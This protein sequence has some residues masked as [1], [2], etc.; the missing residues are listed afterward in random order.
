MITLEQIK[1]ISSST[2]S[3]IVM[4]VLDGLGGLPDP[5]TGKTELETARTPHLDK[6]ANMSMCGL[7]TPIIPGITPGSGPGHLALFGYDP[8][9]FDIG[10]GVLEALGI[11]FDLK[12]D[13]IASR[14]NFCTIDGKGIITDRRA[15]RISTEKCA[16]LCY[17]LN[18]I[19]IDGIQ[20]F[21]LPVKEHRLL[22]VLRGQGLSDRLHDT[23]PQKT[24]AQPIRNIALNN[25]AEY[26]ESLINQFLDKAAGILAD[27]SPANMLL[28]RGFS[29]LPDIPTFKNIYKLNPV[30]I[31]R[32]PM[33][34]GL[35]KLVGMETVK[36][37]SNISEQFSVLSKIY[38]K[39]DFFFIHIKETDS[40]GEDGDFSRKVRVI[41][42]VDTYIP[43]LM[44]L[45]PD[46]IIVTGDH[47]TPAVFKG[48]SWHPVPFL[49]FSNWCRLQR[50]DKFSESNC[51]NGNLGTFSAV[52]IMPLAMGHSLKL[53]KFGA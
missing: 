29:R 7:S 23:D 22:F 47:S 24:G 16:E 26:T 43:A 17:E 39:H 1:Q 6:L 30:A 8:L 11:G 21:I 46:V 34:K 20:Y 33:Y 38:D 49:I 36:A 42:E 41:E 27:H 3:K 32:Y 28:L 13:D 12:K 25:N 18:H 50:I 19:K 52:N 53:S 2:A 37:D 40:A 9:T 10:R 5:N 51:A 15:G 35:A 4:L 14:G 45:K 31:A 48:H 44:D